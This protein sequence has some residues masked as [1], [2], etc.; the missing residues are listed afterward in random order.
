MPLNTTNPRRLRAITQKAFNP[1]HCNP[2]GKAAIPSPSEATR[3]G[4][5][6][7]ITNTCFNR[8][9]LNI[10]AIVDRFLELVARLH[11]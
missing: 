2:H 7:S 3:P 8:D 9:G 4:Y 11:G 10:C 1:T 6:F 5:F